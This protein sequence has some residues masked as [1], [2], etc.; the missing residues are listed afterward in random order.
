MVGGKSELRYCAGYE[1][2]CASS[3]LG[4]VLISVQTCNPVKRRAGKHCL[5]GIDVN[6]L[7][8]SVNADFGLHLTPT[9]IESQYRFQCV[10]VVST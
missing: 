6:L 1:R 10:Y 9:D 4:S 8:E 3:C 5:S 7:D 2:R